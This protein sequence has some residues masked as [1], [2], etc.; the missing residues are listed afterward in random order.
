MCRV[1]SPYT[2]IQVDFKTTELLDVLAK[3][4]RPQ[5]EVK[6]KSSKEKFVEYTK[7]MALMIQEFQASVASTQGK[8]VANN[9][10][11]EEALRVAVQAHLE[12]HECVDR[13]LEKVRTQ[14]VA[15]TSYN[16]AKLKQYK[17]DVEEKLTKLQKE[18]ATAESAAKDMGSN[19]EADA[20][21]YRGLIQRTALL[22]ELP[23]GTVDVKKLRVTKSVDVR[24]DVIQL[25]HN[26]EQEVR[27]HTNAQFSEYCK[28]RTVP[29]K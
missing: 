16:D 12:L 23:E 8:I 25:E 27:T 20:K 11:K 18:L 15:I 3:S 13:S 1:V 6:L 2:S 22:S 21:L 14:I 10:S 29:E 26:M 28:L 5:P 4:S 7:E 17:V 19:P 9:A 24:E